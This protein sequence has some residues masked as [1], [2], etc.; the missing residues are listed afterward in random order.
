MLVCTCGDQSC[1]RL[2]TRI[3]YW[4]LPN[5]NRGRLLAPTNTRRSNH[6]NFAA[7]Q[8]REFGQQFARSCHLARQ[9]IAHAHGQRGRC[10]FAFLNHV[11]V[12]IETR[13][14]VNLGLRQSHFLRQ[15][16]KMSCREAGV[17][18]LNQMQMLD[19]QIGLT[20]HRAQQLLHFN[21]RRR[22]NA[23]TFRRFSL[24]LL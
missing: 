20:R 2:H 13:D 1:H 12:V 9:S 15:R 11:K 21:Q 24:L 18:I 14:L 23:P 22:I 10:S 17:T 16:G 6:A 4:V 19:Q 7:Q 5:D 8:R 3:R